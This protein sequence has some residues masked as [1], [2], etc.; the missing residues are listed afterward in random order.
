MLVKLFKLVKR[1][2]YGN[3]KVKIRNKKIRTK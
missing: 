2:F 3:R 1:G